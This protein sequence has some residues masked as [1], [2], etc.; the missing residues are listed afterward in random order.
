MPG[1]TSVGGAGPRG[2]PRAR[3][4]ARRRLLRAL[5]VAVALAV[6]A[7]GPGAG[8]TTGHRLAETRDELRAVAAEIDVLS[9]EAEGLRAAVA[10]AD[11]RVAE[12]TRRLGLLLEARSTLADEVA[13]AHRRYEQA[14]AELETVAVETFMGLPGAHSDAIAFGAALDAGTLSDV[15]DAVA[16]ASA[17][18]EARSATAERVEEARRR[19]ESRASALDALLAERTAALDDLEHARASL[20]AALAEHEQA[21]VALDASR[22]ELIDLVRRLVERNRAAA[23]GG[24]GA[25]FRGPY[26]VTYGEWAVRLLDAL[27]VPAC[28]NNRVVV[29]AWQVQESTEA[30]W[31]PL[32]TT[33]P[34]PG[35]T[36]FN[37]VGVQNYRSLD[38]GIAAT[39]GTIENG[40]DVYRYGAI[41]EGLTRCADPYETA[42]SIAASS[43]CPGCL[44]GMYVLGLIPEVDAD[45][46]SYSAL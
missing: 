27:R 17:I 44:D 14:R 19:L 12:A 46:A 38:Q 7:A 42:E 33:R 20:A 35:S 4:S 37:W 26:H 9:T 8:A 34:M 11:A 18:G 40:Y 3:P 29:V 22:D 6:V 21:Q 45:L 36:D 15:G 16:Y 31:N 39:L 32:A 1:G 13:D 23:L 25:A 28:R 2:L 41:V 43:W 5:S 24:V 30:A 10:A